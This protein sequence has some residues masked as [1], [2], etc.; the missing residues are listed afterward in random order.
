MG[1]YWKSGLRYGTD[2]ILLNVYPG[3]WYGTDQRVRKCLYWC[4]SAWRDRFGDGFI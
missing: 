2:Q 3:L 1:I 4:C